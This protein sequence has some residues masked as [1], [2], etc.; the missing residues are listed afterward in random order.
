MR[1]IAVRSFGVNLLAQTALL[2][3]VAL[4]AC[5]VDI[6]DTQ[7]DPNAFSWSGPMKAPGTINIRD[8]NGS[9]DV[10]PSTD[11]NVHITASTSSRGDAKKVVEFQ[12]V[13]SGNDVTVCAIWGRGTCSATEYKNKTSSGLFGSSSVNVKFTLLVPTG[14]KVNAATVNGAVD[15]LATAP[16]YARSTNGSLKIGTAIGP[17]DAETVNGSVDARMTTIG[18]D[19][20]L[21]AVTVNGSANLF[22]PD[23]VSGTVSIRNANGTAG[24]DFALTTSSKHALDGVLGAGGREIAV[25]SVN[26]SAFLRRL[27]ADGTVGAPGSGGGA[28]AP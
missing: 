5:S 21:R 8:L 17:V 1:T 9:I 28:K 13:P 18:G 19:G 23:N 2:S 4:A 24:A 12:V 20:A 16:V 15:V 14:V 27:N 26:G 11:D 22:V 3:T 10:R 6:G 25:K 7:T